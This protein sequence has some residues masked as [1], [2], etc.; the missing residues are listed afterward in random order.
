MAQLGQGR[1]ARLVEATTEIRTFELDQGDPAATLRRR[2][3]WSMATD[4]VV[5]GSKPSSRGRTGSMIVELEAGC[6]V[7]CATRL[8]ATTPPRDCSVST[9]RRSGLVWR[10]PAAGQK[11]VFLVADR[12]PAEDWSQSV[13]HREPNGR[14]RDH[15][16]L[17]DRRLDRPQYLGHRS[18]T[19]ADHVDG[20][21][22]TPCA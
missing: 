6:K 3:V 20:S 18:S 1:C 14:C 16:S 12:K 9:R 19:V 7:M 22:K 8:H 11:R 5:S 4:D 2:P 10:T 15:L 13:A 21:P 17:E